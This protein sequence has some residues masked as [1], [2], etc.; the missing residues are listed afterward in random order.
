[1]SAKRNKVGA[2][3][4]LATAF[5]TLGLV[6][7]ASDTSTAAKTV[8]MTV[9]AI[10]K[11]GAPLPISQKDVVVYQGKERLQIVNWRR[12]EKLYIAILIDEAVDTSA[13]SQLN[14]IR[15]F[16]M[17]EPQAT[18]VAVAY[19]RNGTAQVAQD[20]TNDHALAAKALPIPLGSVGAFGSPYRTLQDLMKR[21]PESG[22][23]RAVVL[24]SSGIDYIHGGFGPRSPDLDTTIEHAQRGNVTLYSVYAQGVGHRSRS[25]FV[26]N[27]AQSSLS[28]LAD[29]TGGEAYY[30]GFGTPVA[31][32]PYLNEIGEHLRNQYLLTIEPTGGKKDR[33]ER[34]RVETEI[35]NVEFLAP[36]GVFVPKSE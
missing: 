4:L 32:K 15:D 24:I 11:H 7:A 2:A 9:T 30:L 14:D 28:Q 21:W 20:F 22:D 34:V 35:P 3:L 18:Y 26:V 16:I 19:A 36:S 6:A 8:T 10:G 27:N 31:F 23:R 1:M 17:S 5:G 29:E 33:Y 13:A 12:S 25:F